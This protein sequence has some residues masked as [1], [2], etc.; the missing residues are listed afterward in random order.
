MSRMSTKDLQRDWKR[1]EDFLNA[2]DNDYFA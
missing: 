2:P 1:A